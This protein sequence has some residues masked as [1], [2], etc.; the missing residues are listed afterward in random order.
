[1]RRHFLPRISVEA[2]TK[3]GKKWL[4]KTRKETKGNETKRADPLEEILISPCRSNALAAGN[5]VD[6]PSNA[7]RSFN[8]ISYVK[9]LQYEYKV[10][11]NIFI[12]YIEIYKINGK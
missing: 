7:L 1:M 6:C 3:A 5:F 11:R 8:S 4:V 12:S 9:V 10:N 2:L